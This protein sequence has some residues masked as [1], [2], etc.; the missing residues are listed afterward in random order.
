VH[1]RWEPRATI[2]I[3]QKIRLTSPELDFWVDVTLM[4]YEGRW[5]A[6]AMLSGEYEIGR[7]NSSGEAIHESL[8]ALGHS[9]AT[10]LAASSRTA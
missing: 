2:A 6:V 5:L 8:N 4:S 7:G 10:L 3:V 9:A 1:D